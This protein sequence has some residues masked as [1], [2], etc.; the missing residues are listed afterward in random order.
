[1]R[2]AITAA[3][4]TTTLSAAPFFLKSAKH[5]ND[6][7]TPHFHCLRSDEN[8]EPATCEPYWR[9]NADERRQRGSGWFLWLASQTDGEER[10]QLLAVA[11]DYEHRTKGRVE[12]EVRRL[13]AQVQSTPTPERLRAKA[14]AK[15]KQFEQQ[16]KARTNHTPDQIRTEVEAEIRAWQQR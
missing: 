2:S 11:A 8:G 10:R 13:E 7:T 15:L 1:L 5:F 3:V 16:G 9:M 4:G 6:G 12:Q 14:L